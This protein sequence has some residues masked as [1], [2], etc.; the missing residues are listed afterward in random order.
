[1][2]EQIIMADPS[3]SGWTWQGK[4]VFISGAGS[5]LGRALAEELAVRELGALYIADVNARQLTETESRCRGR[6]PRIAL[7]QFC[8]DVRNYPVFEKILNE[9]ARLDV[10]Y[11]NAGV[12]EQTFSFPDLP[13][14]DMLRVVDIN[15]S[16]VIV[17]TAICIRRMRQQGGGVVIN[18]AS[19]ASLLPTPAGPIYAATKS[20]VSHFTR[21]LAYLADAEQIRVMAVCPSYTE[22]PM[23][24]SSADADRLEAM[25]AEVGGRLLTPS[26]VVQ[27]IV[28]KAETGHGG[29]LMRITVRG[30]RDYWPKL[31]TKL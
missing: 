17:S 28:E 23:V 27:G 22:T 8:F 19:M 7:T 25:R 26:E 4:H 3:L 16:A 14:E 1:V 6:N 12:L 5:G 30:G 10:V 18:T 11:N 15:L 24:F 31:R 21:S 9:V 29:A 20:G 2:A 13:V